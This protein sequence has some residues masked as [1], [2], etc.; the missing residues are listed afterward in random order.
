MFNAEK[1]LLSIMKITAVLLN[2]KNSNFLSL[3]LRKISLINT[4]KVGVG[5]LNLLKIK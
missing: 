1:A 2:G 5:K 3:G 4:C